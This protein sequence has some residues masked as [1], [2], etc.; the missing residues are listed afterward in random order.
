MT[1]LMGWLNL[2]VQL[3]LKKNLILCLR[4]LLLVLGPNMSKE[5]LSMYIYE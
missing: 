4:T 3:K 5:D 1:N 2:T